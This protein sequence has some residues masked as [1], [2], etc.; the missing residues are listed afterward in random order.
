MEVDPDE[1]NR[2]LRVEQ[3]QIATGH[4]LEVGEIGPL[5]VGAAPGAALALTNK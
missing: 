1:A 4:L 2:Q 3:H 5:Q